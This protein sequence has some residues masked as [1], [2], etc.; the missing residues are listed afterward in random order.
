[1]FCNSDDDFL[2]QIHQLRITGNAV[3]VVDSDILWTTLLKI[4]NFIVYNCNKLVL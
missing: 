1:M 3:N 4:N 2:L